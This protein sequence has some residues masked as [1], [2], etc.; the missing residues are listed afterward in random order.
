MK[1]VIL[2]LVLALGL[3]AILW[4]RICDQATFR[5]PGFSLEMRAQYWGQTLSLIKQHPFKGTGMGSF[6]I[7]LARHAHNV[8]LELWAECGIAG[9]ASFLLL[10]SCLLR[11][12]AKKIITDNAP[13]PLTAVFFGVLVFI[14]HNLIDIT[15]F[16]P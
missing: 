6:E 8:F 10:L 11:N 14:F 3:G 15:F 2:L 7:P 1:K 12:G 16:F 4:L 9:I 13:S 5:Q